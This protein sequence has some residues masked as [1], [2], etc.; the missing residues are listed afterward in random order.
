MAGDLEVMRAAVAEH[1]GCK[2]EEVVGFVIGAERQTEEGLNFSSSWRVSSDW[3][4]SGY[5]NELGDHV[6]RA[7]SRIELETLISQ[8]NGEGA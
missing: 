8:N 3:T 4:L 6:K 2:P 1:F 5:I 7:R